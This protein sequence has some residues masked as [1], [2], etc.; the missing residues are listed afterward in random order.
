MADVFFPVLQYSW[1]FSIISS[2]VPVLNTLA[3]YA[4]AAFWFL[5]TPPPE[6]PS[7]LDFLYHIFP[8]A[9]FSGYVPLAPC[10]FCTAGHLPACDGQFLQVFTTCLDLNLPEEVSFS[11]CHCCMAGHLET[12]KHLMPVIL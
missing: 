8:G 12:C 3:A 11:P 6:C 10:H 5:L 1:R 4:I 7:S 2:D 9:L